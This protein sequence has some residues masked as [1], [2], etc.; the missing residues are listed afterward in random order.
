MWIVFRRQRKRLVMWR[1]WRLSCWNKASIILSSRLWLSLVHLNN[2]GCEVTPRN[3]S[4]KKLN[5]LR[6]LLLFISGSKGDTSRFICREILLVFA[7]HIHYNLTDFWRLL[8]LL[9]P[10]FLL[11]AIDF[12]V[13]LMIYVKVTVRVSLPN[14][15]VLYNQNSFAKLKKLVEVFTSSLLKK[16][17]FLKLI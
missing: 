4:L 3:T 12:F 9:S 14:L 11:S 8:L 2:A 7:L 16:Q 15:Q 10:I 5:E 17:P 13:S 6:L 1:C